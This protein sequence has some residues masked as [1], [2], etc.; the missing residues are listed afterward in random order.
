MMGNEWI[1]PINV[2]VVLSV[3]VTGASWTVAS[4]RENRRAGHLRQECKLD[5]Q[6]NLRS[7]TCAVLSVTAKTL[8]F[9]NDITMRRKARELVEDAA[10]ALSQD[11][12]RFAVNTP[13]ADPS[14]QI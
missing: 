10:A 6:V 2:A 14:G 5:V 3:G 4:R 1:G 11:T 8:M 12:D 13:G 9:S 7:A